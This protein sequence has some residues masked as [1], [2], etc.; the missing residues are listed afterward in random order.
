MTETGLFIAG[1]VVSL[2]VF[3]GGFLYAM[4]SFGRWAERNV[5]VDAPSTGV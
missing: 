5:A 1:A 4:F 2:I 3:T